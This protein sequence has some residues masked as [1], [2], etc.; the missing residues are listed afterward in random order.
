MIDKL[1]SVPLFVLQGELFA[2]HVD[3]DPEGTRRRED[4]IL[5]F[6]ATWEALNIVDSPIT[7][8]TEVRTVSTWP[9]EIS[10]DDYLRLLAD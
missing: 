9:T 1:G 6:E 2:A 5:A 7:D 4:N 10:R 3:L 8:A